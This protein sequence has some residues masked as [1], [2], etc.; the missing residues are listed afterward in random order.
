MIL[1]VGAEAAGAAARDERLVADAGGIA[2]AAPPRRSPGPLT[3]PSSRHEILA[4]LRSRWPVHGPIN[5]DFGTPRTASRKQFHAGIDIGA[6][7][8]TAVHAPA[9]GTVAFAGWRSRYGRT[10]ILDHGHQI[11]TLY[12]HLSRVAVK[13][14]EKVERG[15]AVGL[16]GASGNASGPHLHYEVLFNGRPV[17]PRA[18]SF[19][20]RGA[21]Q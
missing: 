19:R 15:A 10:I 1:V 6:R 8:G 11:R 2:E 14:G 13:P 4:A 5:S 7:R 12:G 9:A 21:G 18:A 16:T 20:P 3:R 17:N